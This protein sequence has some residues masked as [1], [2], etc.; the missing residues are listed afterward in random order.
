MVQESLT[1]RTET[2]TPRTW[3]TKTYLEGD[4]WPTDVLVSDYLLDTLD[5]DTYI[6]QDGDKIEFRV[7]NGWARYR[8]TGPHPLYMAV[9][10]LT[11]EDGRLWGSEDGGCQHQEVIYAHV[12]PADDEG[13]A[14]VADGTGAR[15]VD[16][17]TGE[18][19]DGGGTA[20]NGSD[21]RPRSHG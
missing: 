18:A 6:I 12:R 7:A 13:Q 17:S 10:E 20:P 16:A 4:H 15:R 8:R 5:A 21:P 14:V 3:E 2:H 1:F 9:S 11:L 19:D